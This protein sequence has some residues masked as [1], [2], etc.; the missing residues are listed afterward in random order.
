MSDGPDG[1]QPAANG[2][3]PVG[4]KQPPIEHRFQKGHSGNPRGRPRRQSDRSTVINELDIDNLVLQEATRPMSIREGDKVIE[5]PAIQAV[6]RSLG[7]AAVKGNHRAQLAFKDMTETVMLKKQSLKFE[8]F[9]AM[10]EYKMSWE[11]RFAECDR[12]DEPRPEP[13]PHPDDIIIDSFAG[14]ARVVGPQDDHQKRFW[15]LMHSRKAEAYLEIDRQR[16]LLK[17]FPDKRATIAERIALENE[18]IYLADL[19]C[20]EEIIRRAPLYDKE[21]HAEFLE[22]L[23]RET[24][25]LARK[26]SSY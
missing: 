17:R 19:H 14:E 1:Y 10:V 2:N 22:R 25:R 8:F 23:H 3:R 12:N 13:V 18:T 6:M 20:P 7:V 4:Y 16:K 21:S 11:A 15:D 5:L 9:K 24:D 26:T